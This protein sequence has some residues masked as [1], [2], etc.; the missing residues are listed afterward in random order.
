[1]RCGDLPCPWAAV[2]G[3]GRALLHLSRQA[4]H[5]PA[6]LSATLSLAAQ[7]AGIPAAAAA[8]DPAECAGSP[9]SPAPGPPEL[10]AASEKLVTTGTS[11]W[12]ALVDG[13]DFVGAACVP[14]AEPAAVPAPPACSPTAFAPGCR[15]SAL[16]IWAGL[17]AC[18]ALCGSVVLRVCAGA[19]LLCAAEL[20]GAGACLR[21]A[22]APFFRNASARR[23]VSYALLVPGLLAAE[24][25]DALPVLLA[26]GGGAGALPSLCVFEGRRCLFGCRDWCVS[27]G[28]RKEKGV[29]MGLG[30]RAVGIREH[31]PSEIRG[32]KYVKAMYDEGA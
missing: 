32:T 2:A 6:T 13:E 30:A 7:S 4:E 1:M 19:P 14:E 31:G 24:V 26:R 10:S 8:E 23:S 25:V 5:R 22:R 29:I 3:C 17:C 16:C 12:A 21:P 20:R 28:V 15:P 9:C 18:S 27:M 11:T